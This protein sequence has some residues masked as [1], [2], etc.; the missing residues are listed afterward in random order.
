M[1][2][3]ERDAVRSFVDGLTDGQIRRVIDAG[4][5][6]SHPGHVLQSAVAWRDDATD[7]AHVR[8]A[9]LAAL[10]EAGA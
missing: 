1:T 6:R 7:R 3:P 9:L 4:L 10:A 5:A 2:A 8:R